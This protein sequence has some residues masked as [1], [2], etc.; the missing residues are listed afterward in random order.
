M[1]PRDVEF[2]FV[3]GNGEKTVIPIK[4][5]DPRFWFDDMVS[6][7]DME[8][9]LPSVSGEYELYLNLPD[10]RPTL[11]DIPDYSIR[12]ANM[13]IWNAELGYNRLKTITVK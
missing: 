1:N 11:H 7:V 10:P 9:A 6:T 2:V 13:D 8:I 4:D 12:L 5:V 3:S